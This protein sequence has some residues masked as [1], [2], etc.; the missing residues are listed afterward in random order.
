MTQIGRDN[1]IKSANLCIHL[2]LA[3]VHG[4]KGLTSFYLFIFFFLNLNNN[5]T[6]PQTFNV[7][8]AEF[9]LKQLMCVEISTH[10]H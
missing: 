7:A 8:E 6:L 3:Q 4:F 9:D 10:V 5:L 1:K 2:D